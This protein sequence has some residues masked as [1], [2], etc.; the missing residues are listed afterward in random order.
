MWKVRLSAPALTNC[1][2][3]W[4]GVAITPGKDFGDYQAE[5]YVRFTYTVPIEQLREVVER[6]RK[7]LAR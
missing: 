5:K 4:A 6:L 3:Y 2:T 7:H 1:R